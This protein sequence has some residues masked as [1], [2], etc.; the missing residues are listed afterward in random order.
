MIDLQGD[1]TD[2]ITVTSHFKYIVTV[3]TYQSSLAG[4]ILPPAQR[5]LQVQFISNGL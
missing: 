1:A 3:I 4:T 2:T 5:M